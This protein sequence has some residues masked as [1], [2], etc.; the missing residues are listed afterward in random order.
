MRK[1]VRFFLVS[2]RLRFL[3]K[4]IILSEIRRNK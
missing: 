1:Y 3:K 2:F 4:I